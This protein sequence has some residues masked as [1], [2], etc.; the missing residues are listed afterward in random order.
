MDAA[1]L[2]SGPCPLT[3]LLNVYPGL[4]HF[5][6][7]DRRGHRLVAPD[8]PPAGSD[9]SLVNVSSDS[10]FSTTIPPPLSLKHFEL[11]DRKPNE[12]HEGSVISRVNE[13]VN[14]F[15]SADV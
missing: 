8:L 14:D 1:E 5:A 12:D 3:P 11:V 7:V 2:A 13:N 9:L 6:L 15:E 4:V 10:S